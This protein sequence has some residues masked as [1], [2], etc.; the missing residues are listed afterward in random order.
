MDD[1]TSAPV[2]QALLIPNLPITRF[3]HH[4]EES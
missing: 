2:E 1:G 4:Q 3:A